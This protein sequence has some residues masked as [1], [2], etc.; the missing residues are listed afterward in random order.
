MRKWSFLLRIVSCG[1]VLIKW[2]MY[3]LGRA[4]KIFAARLLPNTYVST[5]MVVHF[6]Y[7]LL[8]EMTYQRDLL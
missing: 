8:L 4:L 2:D 3:N 7:G 5:K 6:C 1:T